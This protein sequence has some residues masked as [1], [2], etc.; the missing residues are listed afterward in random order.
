MAASG[1]K[2]YSSG[3]FARKAHVTLRTIRYYDQKNLL[4][5]SMVTAGGARRYT[6]A[7]LAKLQQILL[8]KYLGFSLEDIREMTVASRDRTLLVDSLR[9]QKRMLRERIGEM[10]SMIEAIDETEEALGNRQEINWNSMLELIHLTAMERSLKTQYLNAQN[11]EA[12]IALHR[13]YSKNPEPWFHW[14]LQQAGIRPGMRILEIGCGNGALWTENRDVLP[15]DIGIVLSDISEGMVRETER[16]LTDPRFS[17]GVFDCA[18]LPYGPQCFDLVIAN[19]LLFYVEDIGKVLQEV[20]RVLRPGGAFLAATYGRRHMQ[21]ITALVQEFDPDIVLSAER[22]YERFGLENGAERLVPYF[23]SVTCR[24]YEDAI[25]LDKPEPLI[26][27]ILSCH[28][29]Q[30]SVLLNHYKEF[31]DFVARKVQKGFHITKEAG[32]FVCTR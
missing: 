27:Y 20:R 17:F 32:C 18:A 21:E 31:R 15:E 30:N 9:M 22:L 2:Y 28:G 8:L 13:D 19:H 23:S 4:K 11:I 6:D 26:A 16:Q 1:E 7:D 10:E 14:L 24:R 12:R 3:A 29:N 5:P 25:E